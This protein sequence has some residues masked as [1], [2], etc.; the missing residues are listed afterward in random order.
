MNQLQELLDATGLTRVS[1]EIM[2]VAL[3]SVRLKAHSVEERQIKRGATKFGG[4]PD[5]PA[6]YA[7]PHRDGMPLPFVAQINLS[8]VV[9]YDSL[10]LLPG[11]GMLYFF[12]DIDAFYEVQAQLAGTAGTKYHIA[13]HRLLGHPDDVQWDMHRD[14]EGAPTEWQL[15]FQMDSDGAPDTE[16]GDTGRMYYWI[17]TRDLAKRDFSEAE[18]IL[19]ST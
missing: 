12:F 1:A 6:G 19:Q 18:L 13:L 9:P 4:S 16:W 10:H 17:R 11:E 8:E 15:L 3:P 5:L 7:W 2:Q 14:L